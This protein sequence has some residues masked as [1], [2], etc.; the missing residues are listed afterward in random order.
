[1]GPESCRRSVDSW[2]DPAVSLYLMA[3]S[4]LVALL[5]VELGET[6][7]GEQDHWKQVGGEKIQTGGG[8]VLGAQKRPGPGQQLLLWSHPWEG[9]STI[10]AESPQRRAPEDVSLQEALS[11]L[12][13]FKGPSGLSDAAAQERLPG[14]AALTVFPALGS[15]P[16]SSWG[17]HRR[18]LTLRGLCGPLFHCQ[19]PPG[20]CFGGSVRCCCR[21]R[22]GVGFEEE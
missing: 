7:P 21:K 12:Q 4:L 22:F 11:D 10:T 13:F 6:H 5:R 19:M 1:M 3:E 15:W 20:R 2:P 8:A 9:P 14:A 16:C 17:G 18:S